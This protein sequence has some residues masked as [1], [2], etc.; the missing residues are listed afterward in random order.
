MKKFNK[1][2]VA[3][4]FTGFV[5]F[6]SCGPNDDKGG[7]DDKNSGGEGAIDSTRLTNIDTTAAAVQVPE[8]ILYQDQVRQKQHS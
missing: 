2:T 6:C 7:M 1:G 4:L 3:I 5:V 8:F